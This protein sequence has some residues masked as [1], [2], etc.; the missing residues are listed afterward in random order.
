MTYLSQTRNVMDIKTILPGILLF[1][2][3]TLLGQNVKQPNIQFETDYLDAVNHW[4]VLPQ[5]EPEPNLLLGYVILD[6]IIG[7]TFIFHGELKIE[8]SGKWTVKNNSTNYI[9]K[10]ALNNNTPIVHLLSESEQTM[11]NLP[12]RPNWLRL[13]DKQVRTANELVLLGYHYN[14]ANRSQFAVP[15]LEKALSIEPSARNL[16]FELSYAYNAVGEYQKVVELLKN[17]I[18]NENSNYMLYREL[19]Y[20]LLQLNRYEEADKLYE[21]GM[22]IFENETQRRAMAIDMAQTFF[23]LKDEER[24][25]KWA[26]ILRK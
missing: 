5:K 13:F 24:F 17:E 26:A 19:G 7:F 18:K 25:E 12:E 16:I 22:R 1:F 6:E 4:V 14:K 11:L 9:I 3:T 23:D 21:V 20:A 10:K 2:T 8:S 15:L